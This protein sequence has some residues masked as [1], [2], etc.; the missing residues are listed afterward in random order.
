MAD[1]PV[2]FSKDIGKGRNRIAVVITLSGFVLSSAL[3]QETVRFYIG[4]SSKTLGYSPLWV[5]AKKGFFEQQGLDVQ[6][7]LLRGTPMTVQALAGAS[8]NVGRAARKRLSK[9]RSA[10]WIW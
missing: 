6:L 4:A 9:P 5:A 2:N 7:L 1:P 3:A 10:A 8:L